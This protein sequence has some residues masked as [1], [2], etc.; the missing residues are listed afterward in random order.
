[1]PGPLGIS[2]ISATAILR[3]LRAEPKESLGYVVGNGLG[4][5]GARKVCPGS[6]RAFRELQYSLAGPFENDILA[7]ALDRA[8][9]GRNAA[10]KVEA[11]LGHDVDP[12]VVGNHP[13][14]DAAGRRW[15]CNL[16]WCPGSAV[17]WREDVAQGRGRITGRSMGPGNVQAAS[18][19]H[20]Y[21]VMIANHSA[22][23][24]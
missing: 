6:G 4:T 7:R 2:F 18:W 22:V 11:G 10:T 17:I 19:D 9:D 3:L 12:V 14:R 1:M 5:G 21:L 23:S 15:D 13:V 16:R 20:P 24:L 8:E